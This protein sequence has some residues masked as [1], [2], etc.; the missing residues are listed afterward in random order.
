MLKRF[1]DND[2]P[3]MRALSTAADLLILNLLTIV[4]CLP[5]FTFG[6]AMTALNDLTI[7][8]VRGQDTYL[9]RPF[10]QSF[11]SNF[12]KGVLLGLLV[13]LAEALVVFDVF[14]A[15]N[16]AP[17][18]RIPICAVGLILLAVALYAFALLSRYENSLSATLKNAAALAVAFFPRTVGMLV[19]TV[20][21]WVLAFHFFQYALPLLLLFGF[22]LPAYV[23][24][25]FLNAVFQKLDFE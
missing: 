16:F 6:A 20:G 3:L 25:Q 19:F 17:L 14:L 18:L 15:S 11:R 5:V 4:C 23:C 1:F 21:L 9:V 12:R 13:L 10:F 8:I 2:N 24:A 22:S 7:H